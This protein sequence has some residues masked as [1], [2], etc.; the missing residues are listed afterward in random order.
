MA[1]EQHWTSYGDMFNA[2][3]SAVEHDYAGTDACRTFNN[4]YM[5]AHLS[6]L[7]SRSFHGDDA[8]FLRTA[9]R[10]LGTLGDPGLTVRKVRPDARRDWTAGFSVRAAPDRLHVVEATRDAGVR[11]GECVVAVDG[12]EVACLREELTRRGRLLYGSTPERELWD[13]VLAY[14]GRIEVEGDGG[15]R[16]LRPARLGAGAAAAPGNELRP[17]GDGAFLMRVCD[18]SDPDG[19]ERTVLAHADQ[20][21]RAKTLVVDLRRCRGG[22]FDGIV[23]LVPY[24]VARPTSP[25]EFMG[26]L[27]LYV[28][29][30]HR[31]C[32]RMAAGLE[33]QAREAEQAGNPAEELRREA[34]RVRSLDGAGFVWEDASLPEKWH[35]PVEPAGPE[36][37]VVLSDIG[38]RREGE[39]LLEMASAQ[40]RATTMGRASL[41]DSDYQEPLAVSFED[42]MVFSYPVGATRRAREG[43]GIMGK[44][45]PVQVPVSWDPAEIERDV[46]L[47]RALGLA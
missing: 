38:C 21:A 6:L 9:R 41:G 23:P 29:Y 43:R 19:I 40:G 18:L 35:E 2:I 8:E 24:L 33:Q 17:V 22:G 14:A 4:P 46:L 27:G 44:G 31:N 12:K 42:D 11:P 5:G 39:L 30:S 32:V 37:V 26:D 34:E 7:N 13:T 36:R 3:V 16:T 15:R 28:R 20:I 10:Y 47:E 45:V 1:T 25:A